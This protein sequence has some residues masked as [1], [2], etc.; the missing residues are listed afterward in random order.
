MRV[1]ASCPPR[2]GEGDRAKRGGGGRVQL[3]RPLVYAARKLRKE[4]S[5]PE[6]KL[7]RLLRQRPGGF[8]FRRQHPIDPYVVDFLCR[9]AA[10]IVEVNG[11]VHDTGERAVRD[12]R[13]DAQLKA[14]GFALM[15]VPAADVM[16]DAEAVALGIL[17]RVGSP[18]HR[19]SDG[20]PPRSGEDR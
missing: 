1:V 15:R 14:R 20:P 7:W 3:Q 4:M 18:L 9:E 13:R 5:P 10:L 6:V 8:K 16:G 11:W 19:P 2:D 12:E 17:A